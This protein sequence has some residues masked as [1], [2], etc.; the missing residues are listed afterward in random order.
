MKNRK[1][2]IL[3][4]PL[5]LCF[6]SCNQNGE[7]AK[8]D[9][10]TP[11]NEDIK[12][13]KQENKDEENEEETNEEV[14]NEPADSLDG[15]DA[16]DLTDLI[17]AAENINS[18]YEVH[19]EHFLTELGNENYKVNYGQLLL[20]NF[21]T[22]QGSGENFSL[23]AF[24]SDYI[25][26]HTFERVSINKYK[27]SE[28]AVINDFIHVIIPPLQNEG[29]YLTFDRITIETNNSKIERIRL[30]CKSTQ[31]GKMIASHKNKTEKPNWYLLFA[32]C[33]LL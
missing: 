30:Y 2:V 6:S 11:Q 18:E 22:T 19:H 20:N 24:D 8:N 27:C 1:S 32:E 4:I 13:E 16:T 23:M 3:F 5:F 14:Y 21:T 17:A 28:D 29:Y 25:S 7:I 12:D 15:I 9:T 26:E 10:Y 31:S 33:C